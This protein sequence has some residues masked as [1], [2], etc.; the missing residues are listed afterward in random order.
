MPRGLARILNRQSLRRVGKGVKPAAAAC[1]KSEEETRQAAA[2]VSGRVAR[3]RIP[4]K[5]VAQSGTDGG[6]AR[7]GGRDQQLAIQV[8]TC[9]DDPLD[10]LHFLGTKLPGLPFNCSDIDGGHDEL[11]FHIAV[12]HRMT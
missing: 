12:Q 10:S 6:Q 11:L 5:Q 4:G 9:R 1:R 8:Q 3:L 7:L 2:P